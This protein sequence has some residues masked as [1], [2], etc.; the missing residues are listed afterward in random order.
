MGRV[1]V[2]ECNEEYERMEKWLDDYLEFMYD[3]FVRKVKRIMVD[4]WL[5][6]QVLLYS[7]NFKLLE[8][9]NFS[10]FNFRNNFG[11]NIFVWKILV[12]E[13]DCGDMLNFIVLM[14]DGVWMFFG[15]LMLQM[16]VLSKFY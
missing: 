12:Q 16:L 11:I 7:L 15:L 9:S 3:Y 5:F 1:G 2:I 4:G 13:F 8:I 6:V 10:G 14:V